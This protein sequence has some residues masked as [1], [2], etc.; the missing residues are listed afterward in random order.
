MVNNSFALQTQPKNSF[1]LFFISIPEVHHKAI[2]IHY[3]SIFL[4]ILVFW[5]CGF[6]LLYLL[7]VLL[8]NYTMRRI[9]RQLRNGSVASGSA[10]RSAYRFLIN[11]AGL[12]YYISL[13]IILILLL[14]LVVWVFYASLIS[15]YLPFHWMFI[16]FIGTCLTIHSMIR[17]LM[18]KIE[19]EDSG[20]ELKR[21]E[22]PELFALTKEVAK[23]L[24]TWEIDEIRITPETDLAVY[25]KGSR[26]EKRGD[27]GKR[28]LI[29]GIGVLTGF[30]QTD[31]R[32]V[33]A[34]E[35]GHF[36]HRDTAGGEIA[37]RVRRDMSIYAHTL[38][39]AG[40]TVWWN[41]A[42]QFLRLYHFIFRRISSGATRF[43]EIR[44]DR[45]AAQLY[46][47]PAFQSGLTHIIRRQ[48]EFVKLARAEIKEAKKMKR[49][50]RNLYD[51]APFSTT[52]IEEELSTILNR[53]TDPDDT[54]PSPV[55]RFR[56][57]A[58][59]NARAEK[60]TDACVP[61]LFLDWPSIMQEMTDTIEQRWKKE[62]Q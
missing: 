57:L 13:P 1:L 38:Y 42:F 28:I 2:H 7:G 55:D 6:F 17:S 41:I 11:V 12:Y 44:A 54:H 18:L 56:Y 5:L 22:A 30:K 49:P 8:S 4:G 14:I 37:L 31:F 52:D 24:D 40:Q 19:E 36:A 15:G 26:K 25:E 48:I 20:R 62:D 33:L 53:K 29:L 21:S 47:L 50:F 39:L 32:A 45:V 51:L 23:A 27:R 16:L 61:E 9:E 3:N 10:W 46:G 35:Y 59:L 58:G 34:H 60:K 43:Q